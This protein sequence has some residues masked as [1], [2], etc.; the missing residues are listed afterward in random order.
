M[1]VN[2]VRF[3]RSENDEYIAVGDDILRMPVY[4][5]LRSGYRMTPMNWP[6]MTK[7]ALDVDILDNEIAELPVNLPPPNDRDLSREL[8]TAILGNY[9]LPY[10]KNGATEEEAR[11]LA[12]DPIKGR[13]FLSAE[14]W[15]KYNLAEAWKVAMEA[16]SFYRSV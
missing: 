11:V 3:M 1:E 5:K 14:E 4:R 7:F 15:E 10:M 16:R 2:Y 12:A 9:L 6:A 8:L 13:E